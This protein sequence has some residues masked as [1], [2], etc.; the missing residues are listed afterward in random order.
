MRR[1]PCSGSGG[2]TGSD[3]P[4]GRGVRDF[5]DM[6]TIWIRTKPVSSQPKPGARYDALLQ[7]LRTADTIWNSSRVFFGR[8]DL[9]PG[10]VQS[11][12]PVDGSRGWSDA[13][14]TEPELLTHRSNIT[15]WWAAWRRGD[16]WRVGR[17][18]GPAG[19]AGGVDGGRAAVDGGTCCP[20]IFGLQSGFGR[21][22][23]R[24]AAEVGEALRQVA[25]NTERAAAS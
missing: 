5:V 16:W 3:V 6:S 1:L 10:A 24:R 9:E 14:R 22:P 23:A 17:R 15:G 11:P 25:I 7:L 13:E 19:M 20:I 18:R 8:W 12:Q 2:K 21:I 4:G